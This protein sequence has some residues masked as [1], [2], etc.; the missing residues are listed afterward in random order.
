MAG[1]LTPEKFLADTHK[2]GVDIKTQ[3]AFVHLINT[4]QESVVKTNPIAL[5]NVRERILDQNRPD[6]IFDVLQLAQA[7]QK[8]GLHL[9]D[10][11]DLKKEFLDTPMGTEQ[12][13]AR[14]RMEK[15]IEARLKLPVSGI[16]DQ[17]G[18]GL[19]NVAVKQFEK[20]RDAM[21]KEGKN[22]ASLLDPTSKDYFPNT[23]PKRSFADSMKN[24]AQAS[25]QGN[26]A[27]EPNPIYTLSPGAAPN[28]VKKT[29][30][31]ITEVT[32]KGGKVARYDKDG[33]LI[34]ETK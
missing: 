17:D 14:K 24:L 28:S 31:G 21:V 1:T 10:V 6:S 5:N 7:A 8:A 23:I 32:L 34:K 12:K 13:E 11:D 15:D 4:A 18:P 3:D 16:T 22:P 27:A 25:V 26:K 2:L 9:K 19:V 29:A 20:A 30:D 33:K